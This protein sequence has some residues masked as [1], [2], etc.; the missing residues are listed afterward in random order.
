[1]RTDVAEKIE[2]LWQEIMLRFL[3]L[4]VNSWH[5]IASN[6]GHYIHLTDCALLETTIKSIFGII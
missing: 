2:T 1:M 5:R 4:S 6:S 3:S